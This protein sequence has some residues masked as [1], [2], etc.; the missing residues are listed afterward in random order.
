MFC[1]R[2]IWVRACS[3]ALPEP[4]AADPERTRRAA[5]PVP[6]TVVELDDSQPAKG[7][8]DLGRVSVVSGEGGS[9]GRD[10]IRSELRTAAIARGASHLRYLDYRP[11]AKQ[12]ETAQLYYCEISP[13]PAPAPPPPPPPTSSEDSIA[14][15]IRRSYPYG[16]AAI[17]LELVPVGALTIGP[18]DH[19]AKVDAE[20]TWGGSA[21]LEYLA[22]PYMA[23]GL[24]PGIVFGLKGTGATAAASS[25]TQLDL[26]VR[27]RIG[28]LVTTHS[29]ALQGYATAG[30]SWVFPM[31]GDGTARG[32]IGGVGIAATVPLRGAQFVALDAGYQYGWQTVGGADGD[33]ST[34]FLHLGV[35]LDTYL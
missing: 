31:I 20:Q 12:R 25:S 11:G 18:Q 1:V 22:A 7:C 4:A 16:A 29:F 32:L 33:F 2:A 3:P 17:Q 9:R 35:G 6:G 10:A 23:I 21:S 14:P 28:S 34:R 19:G 5:A 27:V 8:K 30:V 13:L 15:V 24:E 26:R